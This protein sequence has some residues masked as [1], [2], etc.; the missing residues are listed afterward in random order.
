METTIKITTNIELIERFRE[1]FLAAWRKGQEAMWEIIDLCV[2][3]DRYGEEI[4]QILDELEVDYN[5]FR[6][7]QRIG[8]AFPPNARNLNLS[9]SHHEEVA[10]LLPEVAQSFLHLA[11]EKNWS[12]AELRQKIK[13]VELAQAKKAAPPPTTD[14]K[15]ELKKYLK[16]RPHVEAIVLT[17]DG[18]I[19]HRD[20]RTANTH[21]YFIS[22]IVASVV[23]YIAQFKEEQSKIVREIVKRLKCFLTD[24]ML[25]ANAKNKNYD[26]DKNS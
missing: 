5:Q 9:V 24:D 21:E 6:R 17:E 20:S 18:R 1:R 4:Y 23:R 14:L 13:E 25:D 26:D 7:W 3:A 12:R 16:P 22:S 8:Y 19:E 11:Q 2:E 10:K 15:P